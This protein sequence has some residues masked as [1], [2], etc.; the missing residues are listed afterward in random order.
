MNNISSATGGLRRFRNKVRYGMGQHGIG[1]LTAPTDDKLVAPYYKQLLLGQNFLQKSSN[2]HGTNSS[3]CGGKEQAGSTWHC[4]YGGYDYVAIMLGE[5]DLGYGVWRRSNKYN[6]SVEEQIR[7]SADGLFN[8]LA[9]VRT[10]YSPS[11]IVVMGV[12]APPMNSISHDVWKLNMRPYV[13]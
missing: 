6:T 1:T 5:V 4:R 11:A 9:E 8:F 13:T 10:L 3:K 12:V 7:L 2:D